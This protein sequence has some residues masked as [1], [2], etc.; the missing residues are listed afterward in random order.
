MS[1]KWLAE[2]SRSED[3]RVLT[4]HWSHSLSLRG[5]VQATSTQR[6]HSSKDLARIY[7]MLF[8]SPGSF[9]LLEHLLLLPDKKSNIP[10][11]EP[12][13]CQP[14]LLG[15]F[16]PLDVLPVFTEGDGVYFNGWHFT[17]FMGEVPRSACTAAFLEETFTFRFGSSTVFR[18]CIFCRH[19]L[20]SGE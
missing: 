9:Q 12:R 15:T 6:H 10:L 2:A 13:V 7:S 19:A 11:A 20:H 18:N 16:S 4:I 8:V 17:V 5:L 1:G 3:R 14:V